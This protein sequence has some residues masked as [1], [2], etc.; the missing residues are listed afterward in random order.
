MDNISIL[1]FHTPGKDSM[2]TIFIVGFNERTYNIN[3]E[4]DAIKVRIHFIIYSLVLVSISIIR[5][6]RC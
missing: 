6:Q 4:R 3:F 1:I 2:D 5:I